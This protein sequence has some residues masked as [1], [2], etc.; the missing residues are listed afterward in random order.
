MLLIIRLKCSVR[1]VL[2]AELLRAGHYEAASVWAAAAVL[3]SIAVSGIVG[4]TF[5]AATREKKNMAAA[6]CAANDLRK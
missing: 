3:Y 5:T 6:E 1:S 4:F 2:T